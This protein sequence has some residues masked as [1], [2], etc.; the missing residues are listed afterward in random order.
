MGFA[1]LFTKD[2]L[3]NKTQTA[4]LPWPPPESQ[5]HDFGVKKQTWRGALAPLQPRTPLQQTNAAIR[6][7][8]TLFLEGRELAQLLI[9]T[10][11]LI[12]DNWQVHKLV[13]LRFDTRITRKVRVIRVSIPGE[14]TH[15]SKSIICLERNGIIQF[16][17]R[18]V[19]TTAAPTHNNHHN[20]FFHFSNYTKNCT[21]RQKKITN[22]INA[23]SCCFHHKFSSNFIYS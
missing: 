10:F 3:G 20:E 2:Y 18:R 7:T 11:Q 1:R 8:A 19:T 16:R 22:T 23:T 5:K 4:M 17:R 6:F 14:N 12:V 9:F 15:I 13:E 21:P